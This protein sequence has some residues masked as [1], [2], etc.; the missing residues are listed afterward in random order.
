MILTTKTD[1]RRDNHFNRYDY[2]K[3]EIM[4]SL[5]KKKESENECC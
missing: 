4:K 5:P 1:T 2:E 3:S